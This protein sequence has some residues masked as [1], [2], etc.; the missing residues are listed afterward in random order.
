VSPPEHSEEQPAQEPRSA[1]ARSQESAGEASDKKADGA[2]NGTATNSGGGNWLSQMGSDILAQLLPLVISAGGLAAL[3]FGV[4]GAVSMARFY[5]AG[6]P[7]QQALSAATESD[8]RAIGLTWLVTFGLLGLLAVLLAY[9]ASPQGKATAA[10]YYL[11]IAMAASEA[12]VVWSLG[13]RGHLWGDLWWE[14]LVAAGIIVGGTAGAAGIVLFLHRRNRREER[15]SRQGEQ[16]RK[17]AAGEPTATTTKVAKGGE[18]PPPEA[19]ATTK[20]VPVA[21]EP[22]LT[23]P[24]L[25]ADQKARE[26]PLVLPLWAYVV[27]GAISLAAGASVGGLLGHWWVALAIIFAGVLALATIRVADLTASFRWYGVCV[28]FSIALFG[29]VLGVLR[30]L[31][32]PRLQ[33]VAFL[34]TQGDQVRAMQGV[35]VGE[36]DDRLWFASVALDECG[37]V[38]LRRGSGRLRSVPRD[39]VSFVSIGP[40]MG[41]P[42]LAH[43]SQAMLDDVMAEH[44][45]EETIVGPGAVR[46]T[47]AVNE[48][49]IRRKA[50]GW[51]LELGSSEDFGRHPSVT[52]RGRRLRLRHPKDGDDED[53]DT[54]QVRLPRVARSGAVYVGCGERTNK[55]WLTVPERPYA[56]PT[57]TGLGGGRWRLDA[58]GSFDPDGQIQSYVWHLPGEA[59]PLKGPTQEFTTDDGGAVARLVVIDDESD[60]EVNKPKRNEP[61]SDDRDVRLAGTISRTFPSDLLFCHDCRHLKDGAAKR[62]VGGLQHDVPGARLVVVRAHTDE[63]GSAGYNDYLSTAR[64]TAV[65]KALLSGLKPRPDYRAVGVGED[66]PSQP[67]DHRANRRIEVL[68][69]RGPATR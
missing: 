13:S 3:V 53:A 41:L 64:A 48:L 14:D 23:N 47:V 18:E 32:E 51:W 38:D 7:A 62:R 1:S 34:Q 12:T 50:S 8:V 39:Q 37:D 25:N 52:L 33:S 20:P 60:D 10:M 29:A 19:G 45:G 16:K 66:D 44:E 63:R 22:S 59:Q 24:A 61:L 5:A 54:W 17:E 69:Y 15:L 58:R 56:M 6:L 21:P 27:L 26:K 57:A 2:S 67:G 4:G 31:E 43:E 42:K 49:G 65:V 30:M 40:P 55:A 46:D 9:L 11:L 68:I 36:S 35:Y 28:F